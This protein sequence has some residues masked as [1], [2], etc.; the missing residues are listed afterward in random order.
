[1][2]VCFGPLHLLYRKLIVKILSAAG[3]I[4][5]LMGMVAMGYKEGWVVGGGPERISLTRAQ[6]PAR[7]GFSRASTSSAIMIIQAER[8]FARV[9]VAT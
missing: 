9:I 3:A 7:W 2:S 4:T 6:R 1:M 5:L 8:V